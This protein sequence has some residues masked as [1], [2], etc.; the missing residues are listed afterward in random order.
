M[1]FNLSFFF[2]CRRSLE[3]LKAEDFLLA[4]SMFT[5]PWTRRIALKLDFI[6]TNR[7]YYKDLK[8]EDGSG[9]V[10]PKESLTPEHYAAIMV[11]VL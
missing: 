3:F 10:F 5:N 2:L 4:Q 9:Y 11:K 7:V 1:G 6:E 8:R